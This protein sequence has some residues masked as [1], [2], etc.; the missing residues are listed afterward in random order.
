MGDSVAR[1]IDSIIESKRSDSTKSQMH[2]ETVIYKRVENRTR[3]QIITLHWESKMSLRIG[4]RKLQLLSDSRSA[5]FNDSVTKDHPI[6][7]RAMLVAGRINRR[8]G[9]SQRV[10]KH[11]K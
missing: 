6:A 1:F 4:L 5:S 7:N 3:S 2:T 8:N 10:N 9:S 11:S